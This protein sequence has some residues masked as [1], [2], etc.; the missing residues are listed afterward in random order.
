MISGIF[1]GSVSQGQEYTDI[2]ESYEKKGDKLY[3]WIKERIDGNEKMLVEKKELDKIEP[4]QLGLRINAYFNE[5]GTTTS[6]YEC[7]D[8]RKERKVNYKIG[9]VTDL[10]VLESIKNS[11]TDCLNKLMDYAKKQTNA[12]N[13]TLDLGKNESIINKLNLVKGEYYYAYLSMDDENGTYEPVEDVSLYQAII[14]TGE[15]MCLANYTDNRFVWNLQNNE[16][17]NPPTDEKPEK[18]PSQQPQQDNTIATTPIPQTGE[19]LIIIFTTCILIISAVFAL[20]Q[21]RKN[22][23]K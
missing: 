9:K 5:N 1:Y 16:E 13:G 4:L 19:S 8:D 3:I 21:I 23:F 7:Y 2:T 15:N 11:E 18:E 10:S 14:S 6:L 12:I 17:E 20:I 22:N